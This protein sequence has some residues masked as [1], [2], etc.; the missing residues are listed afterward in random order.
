MLCASVRDQLSNA[1]AEWMSSIRRLVF[2][3]QV[4]GRVF[5][6]ESPSWHMS[7]F[8]FCSS[9]L[10]KAALHDSLFKKRIH[11]YLMLAFTQ[12]SCLTQAVLVRVSLKHQLYFDWP[13]SRSL[14]RGTAQW[15][16]L[17]ALHEHLLPA[18]DGS[19]EHNQTLLLLHP[20]DEKQFRG[21]CA[22]DR[23]NVKKFSFNNF[24]L[25]LYRNSRFENKNSLLISEL[26]MLRHVFGSCCGNSLKAQ[27]LFMLYM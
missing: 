17:P 25:L 20:G 2:V 22:P 1:G 11:V 26:M 9:L 19:K 16:V 10:E 5:D 24:N 21:C 14:L 27:K 4:H 12:P 23:K 13:T 8:C 15:P 3:L 7:L 6:V 18:R